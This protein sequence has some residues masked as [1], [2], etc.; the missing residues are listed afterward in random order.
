MYDALTTRTPPV[1]HGAVQ[2]DDARQWECVKHPP[3][4][5]CHHQATRKQY[6]R[7]SSQNMRR[8]RQETNRVRPFKAQQQHKHPTRYSHDLTGDILLKGRIT[9]DPCP[10]KSEQCPVDAKT[11][12]TLGRWVTSVPNTVTNT[13]ST[14]VWTMKKKIGATAHLTSISPPI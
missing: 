4:V 6:H 13:M 2:H 11:V 12:Q 7:V 5:N 14:H 9:D 3:P 10:T 8:D 1:L